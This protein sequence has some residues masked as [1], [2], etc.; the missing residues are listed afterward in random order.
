[1][2]PFEFVLI[3]VS[4]VIGL[5]LTEFA[6]GVAEM[7]KMYRTAHYYWAH[8]VMC[9]YGFMSCLNYW[10]TVYRLRHIKRWTVSQMGIV[11][12]TGM[13]FFAMTHIVLPNTEHF[14]QN[15]E[16]Y[17]HENMTVIFI[18]MISFVIFFMLESWMI[19]KLRKPKS[20]LVGIGFIAAISSGVIINNESYRAVLTAV[21]MLL[22]AYN[23]YANKVVINETVEK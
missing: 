7:I 2:K 23:M 15:Y 17:F 11:F 9:I 19:R 4:V 3:I 6:L 1:M 12:I 10:G 18:L 8:F 21:L 13:I 14:D 20:Y 22:Q 16:R 5:A